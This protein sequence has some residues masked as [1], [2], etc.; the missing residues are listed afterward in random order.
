[1]KILRFLSRLTPYIG[2]YTL[3]LHLSIALR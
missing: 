1:M 3:H 2:T